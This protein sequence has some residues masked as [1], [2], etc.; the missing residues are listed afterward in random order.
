MQTNITSHSNMT[1]FIGLTITVNILAACYAN[2][3]TKPQN[4]AAYANDSIQLTCAS[5]SSEATIYW[6]DYTT[7]STG[8]LIAVNQ[9]T[10]S[11]PDIDIYSTSGIQL[12]NSIGGRFECEQRLPERYLA[13]VDI[14]VFEEPL[15]CTSTLT[16]TD[17]TVEE[18]DEYSL[19]C[20]VTYTGDDGWAPKIDWKDDNGIISDVIDNSEDGKLNVT[21]IRIAAL[22]QDG[23]ELSARL[24]F[25]AYNGTLPPESASNIPSFTETHTFD[26]INVHYSPRDIVLTKEMDE[27]VPGDEILCSATGNPPPEITW[28]HLST[29]IVIENN[30][31]VIT[32]EMLSEQQSYE[33]QATNVIKGTTRND[34]RSLVFFVN[35]APNPWQDEIDKWKN[36]SIIV[37][38]VLGSLACILA[39]A[40]LLLLCRLSRKQG[41]PD[42]PKQ[43]LQVPHSGSQQQLTDF[44]PLSDI[45]EEE[46]GPAYINASYT[47]DESSPVYVNVPNQMRPSIPSCDGTD[48][49]SMSQNT[50]SLPR[51][52]YEHLRGQRTVSEPY[53]TLEEVYQNVGASRS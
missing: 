51:E 45:A 35:P 40:N 50:E 33:C 34:T 39:I 19:T 12:N 38:A 16:A 1:I 52:S 30:T 43:A 6:F 4:V 31:L 37:G 41:H 15:M 36:T 22:D 20:S 32:D 42:A 48:T 2:F 7:N 29:G 13:F 8:Q 46:V 24:H 28:R 17:N 47:K 21:I 25:V 3:V 26:T 53:T 14:I 18:G 10:H 11:S 44:D 5:S 23:F 9:I 49:S 27:Y